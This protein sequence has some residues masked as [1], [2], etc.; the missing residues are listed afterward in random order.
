MTF[1]EDNKANWSRAN[2]ARLVTELASLKALLRSGGHGAGDPSAVA[3]EPALLERPPALD[4]L[5][6][7][8][9][10]SRFERSLLLLC[11]APE[12]DQECAELIASVQGNPARNRPTFGLALAIL[13]GAHWSAIAPNGVLRQW[14]LIELAPGAA[15]TSAA[16]QI[17]ERVLHFL[18][19]VD[20]LDSRLAHL[21]QPISLR[22]KRQLAP[23][24]AQIAA[25]IAA[26]WSSPAAQRNMPLVQLCGDPDDCLP[27]LAAAADEC[28]TQASVIGADLTP[29]GGLEL[30]AFVRL[31]ER[32]A[33]LSG[34][35]VLV[36]EREDFRQ[37]ASE[38]RRPPD[39]GV[40]H[41]LERVSGRVAITGRQRTTI[42]VRS[43]LTLEVS[44]PTAAEQRLLWCGALHIPAEA[45]AAD[46]QLDAL[47]AQF[48]LSAA[49]I[50]AVAADAMSI[51]PGGALAAAWSVC[52]MFLRDRMEGLA[53]RITT[54][55]GWPDLVLPS[56]E[57]E[58]LHA[59]VA[60]VRQRRTV[61]EKWG[62]AEKS[63]RGLGTSVL[64]SG[65]S[66]TGKTLAAEV[67]ANEMG[68]DL[69][70]IDL[71]GV[72]S[73]YI[74]ES[75]K[76]LRKVFDA[77]EDS[78]A[79]LLFDEADALF[80]ARSV[81]KDSHDRYANIQV[82]Y[83]LQRMEAYRGLAILTTNQKSALDPAFMRRLRFV[84]Q[85]PFPDQ[86]QRRAIWDAVFPH[87]AP[88]DG[89]DSGRLGQLKVA[90]G[91][92]R[93]IAMNAAF[94]AAEARRPIRMQDVLVAT[95]AEYTKLERSLTATETAGWL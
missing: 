36:I 45:T 42:T 85:F 77:A 51:A 76:A 63:G 33:I 91:N 60:Q 41:L 55:A 83:L 29:A 18:L 12:L 3:D 46:E 53:Q 39:F 40:V 23:S 28:D 44:H 58:V 62:F 89:L 49:A 4:S 34:H 82:S 64:F 2:H 10:L 54:R 38:E 71:S 19:G 73:K 5:S 9:E 37:T 11:A 87:N 13:P 79:I 61:Y 84:V 48:N 57:T 80:G 56:A 66:G 27:I 14:R 17:D 22:R 16:L 31:W 67:L 25:E 47:V 52:R 59:V 90:G 95:R 7:A 50:R 65:P 20:Q 35:G 8:F 69:Y 21:V 94:L 15:L 78:G 74:G 88:R 81:V 72:V 75:E 43:T 6:Q 24:H 93:N 68:L 70:R 32:E 86:Q 1:P 26:L 30:D 92:I